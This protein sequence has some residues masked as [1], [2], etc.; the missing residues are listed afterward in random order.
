MRKVDP[1]RAR[2]RRLAFFTALL[3]GAGLTGRGA[4]AQEEFENWHLE[5]GV[6][7]AHLVMVARVASISRLTVVE[8]AKTDVAL[9]EYRFQPIRRLKGLF[10]RDELS[11]TASDLGC[12]ADEG[13][14]AP[15][16]KEGEFRLL[17]LVQPQG[18]GSYGCVSAAQGAT[19]FNERVP[20]LTG[21]DDPLVSVVETLIRVADSRSRRERA[22]LLLERL[23][24]VDGLAAVPLL[25]SLKLRADWA[26]ADPRAVAPVAPWEGAGPAPGVLTRLVRSPSP[27]VRGA[28]VEVVR[29]ILAN[30]MSPQDPQRLIE[31]A[32]A[33]RGV[34]ES[35]QPV[36]RIRVAALEGL[37]RLLPHLGEANWPR[38]LL[39]AQLN[40]AATH[41][42]RATAVAALSR[43][44]DPADSP[45]EAVTDALYALPLDEPTV[46]EAEYARAAAQFGAEQVLIDRLERSIR[47]RQPLEAEVD[48][49]GRMRSAASL[50]LLLDAAGRL[51]LDSGDR[52]LIARAL[53]RVGNDRA[54]PVL[55]AWVRSE[56]YHLREASLAALEELDSE[57]AAR[58]LRPLLKTEPHLPFKL[59]I[60]RVL[61]RHGLADGYALATE[62]L[63]DTDHTAAAALVLAA[64]DDPRTVGD[65]SAIVAARPDRRWHAAA[66]TGLA[67]VGDAAAGGQQ[68]EILADDRH[69]LAADAAQ[70]VGLS[71]DA[72]LLPP[73]AAL[74]QSRNRQIALASLTALRRFFSGV[75]DSP[76]GLA[77]ADR[78]DGY[79]AD[80]ELPAPPAE[81]PEETRAVLSE[82]VAA[83]VL[84]AYVDSGVRQEALA[85]AAL[86]R[87]EMYEETLSLLADQSELE[88]TPL[89][90][91]VQVARRR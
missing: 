1:F 63:A 7:Q 50:P 31:V 54:I 16:L 67:A 37:G 29:E 71:A 52:R 48:A 36:T 30:P 81:V 62:H 85:V 41:A 24:D 3:S 66:L 84:D 21:P 40:S 78:E 74:V 64:L 4:T 90:A 56:D 45:V 60:A 5:P 38:V 27:A 42:E 8:G 73:L 2:L 69:P 18:F 65:L 80:R 33:L 13:A 86:L 83:L 25:S 70:A 82:A 47:A 88:G 61:A 20:L 72:E 35:D 23:A 6:G 11:M 87:G 68:L 22:A 46:L 12:R 49:L 77:A 19:T 32:E 43:T 79:Q 15:T 89:L 51:N 28:A 55:A 75:R 14:Q 44:L 34:I 91:Q 57:A 59:R 10:Q 53:G 39:I 17:I 76:R 58:E 26:A 9:R